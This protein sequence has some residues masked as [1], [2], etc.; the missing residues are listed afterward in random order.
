MITTLRQCDG[1]EKFIALNN[2]TAGTFHEL[3]LD[4]KTF[5]TDTNTAMIEEVTTMARTTKGVYCEECFNKF[6][7]HMNDFLQEV[8]PKLKNISSPTVTGTP[9][10]ISEDAK[11]AQKS[12]QNFKA[13]EGTKLEEK[14]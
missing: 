3:N 10:D 12:Q 9:I 11:I 8:G 5:I 7:D 1:C 2:E 4:F 13:A 6:V 14:K